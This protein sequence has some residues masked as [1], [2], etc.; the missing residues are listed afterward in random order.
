MGLPDPSGKKTISGE[1]LAQSL[2]FTQL[3]AL[4]M[5]FLQARIGLL[6]TI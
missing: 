2:Y 1:L 3:P 4:Y 5:W 6:F